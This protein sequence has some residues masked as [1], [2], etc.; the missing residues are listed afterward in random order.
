MTKIQTISENQS[1]LGWWRDFLRQVGYLE[2]VASIEE[3]REKQ[4]IRDEELS[5]WGAVLEDNILIFE[6]DE[7]ATLFVMRWM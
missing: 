2:F 7:D 4:R 1:Y 6:N 3:V 5:R